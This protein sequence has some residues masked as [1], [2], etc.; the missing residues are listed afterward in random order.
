MKDDTQRTNELKCE[1]W[2]VPKSGNEEHG[3]WLR[4]RVRWLKASDVIRVIKNGKVKEKPIYV[5]IGENPFWS[6]VHKCW[7]IHLTIFEK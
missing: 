6:E 1:K 7:D 5:V 2:C 3:S 4:T